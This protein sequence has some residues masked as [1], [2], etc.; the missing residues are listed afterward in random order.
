[1]KRLVMLI[2]LAMVATLF[3]GC[4]AAQRAEQQTEMG[5]EAIVAKSV[6]E[7]FPV[8]VQA[9]MAEGFVPQNINEKYGILV[10]QPKSMHPGRLMKKIGQPGGGFVS[11]G[12][13]LTPDMMD[14][15]NVSCTVQ[16]VD[17][18]HC[19]VNLKTTV[20]YSQA[21]GFGTRRQ[22]HPYRSAKANEYYFQKI[23]SA[24]G[25]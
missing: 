20:F 21:T 17:E 14:E 16:R 13:W 11:A 8:I 25:Q 5:K 6:D 12:S 23:M 3:I 18:G 15:I 1:M 7:V 2:P 19:K 9:L 22:L 10:M 4:A 24:I